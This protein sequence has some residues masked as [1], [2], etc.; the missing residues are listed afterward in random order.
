MAKSIAEKEVEINIKGREKGSLIVR[1]G[2]LK[3]VAIDIPMDVPVTAETISKLLAD[4]IPDDDR[5][6]R[7]EVDVESFD[8]S[9]ADVFVGKKI[10]VKKPKKE[11]TETPR[12][13][14]VMVHR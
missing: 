12:K 13:Q 6:S 8:F 5:L 3:P 14:T 2:K 4:N 10:K 9:A 1:Y 11:T 7:A